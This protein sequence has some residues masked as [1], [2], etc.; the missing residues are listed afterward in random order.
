MARRGD[1]ETLRICRGQINPVLVFSVPGTVYSRF[2][3]ENAVKANRIGVPISWDWDQAPVAA[4]A[5]DS[6]RPFLPAALAS[7]S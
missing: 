4:D 5:K 1:N 2:L 3:H 6:F 7:D